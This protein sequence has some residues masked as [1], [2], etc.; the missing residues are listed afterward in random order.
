MRVL[1]L[2]LLLA[3]AS[4]N[5]LEEEERNGNGGRRI[6]AL[7]ES[8]AIRETHSIFFKTLQDQGFIVTFRVADDSNINLKKYGS[9][10]YDHLIVFAPSVEEFGGTLSVEGVTE[11]IDGGGNVLVAGAGDTG[12]VLREIA[13]ECGFEAGEEGSQVIDHLNFDLSKDDGQHTTVVADPA[14]LIKSD[15]IVGATAAKGAPF[16]YRGTGLLVDYTNPLVIEILTASS[17]AYTHKPDEPINVFPHSVGKNA[18]LI[19]G[20]QARNNA[21]YSN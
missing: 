11:F 2:V 16:L 9:W 18:V 21:R 7:L 15:K 12:D 4:S 20:L 14:N 3:V 1:G 19:A 8:P 5:C 6:L 13:A 10:L 17:S